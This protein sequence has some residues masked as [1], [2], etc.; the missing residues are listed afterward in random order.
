MRGAAGQTA[1]A[2][3]TATSVQAMDRSVR[4]MGGVFMDA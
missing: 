3:Q 4:F 2:A 1:E